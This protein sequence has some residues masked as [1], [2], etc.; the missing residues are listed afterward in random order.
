MTTSELLG[1]PNEG[2][3]RHVFGFA[4]MDVL[5]TMAIAYLIAKYKKYSF[6]QTFLVLFLIGELFHLAF[7]VRTAFLRFLL[8]D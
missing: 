2:F 6:I 3:H 4:I 1:K 8:G 5:G 7:G